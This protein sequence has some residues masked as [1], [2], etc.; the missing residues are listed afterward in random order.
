M[1]AIFGICSGDDPEVRR[2]EID[3]LRSYLAYRGPDVSG[4]WAE[5]GIAIGNCLLQTTPESLY[6]AMPAGEAVGALRITAD[7]RL[8]NR[9]EL[10]GTLGL[11]DL[12]AA[13]TPDSRLILEA[14]LKWGEDCP[15]HLLGD[16]AFAIWDR[17][18]RT[19]FCARDQF[20][21]KPF[22]YCE[23]K[24][25]FAFCSC[26]DGLLQF[27]WVPRRLN[28][29]RLASHLTLFYG[30][31]AT[32]FYADILRLP[33]A[34]SLRVNQYGV[35]LARYWKLDPEIET[36]RDSDGQ[37]IEEFKSIFQEAVKA[38]LRTNG[39]PGSMLSGGLDS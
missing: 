25:C 14:F 19:L 7:A 30:D 34:H 24:G 39:K 18:T 36:L 5:A 3:R 10:I 22:Y 26:V 1:S 2:T 9:E 20:G 11:K 31:T 27:E 6:E 35:R 4:I 29:Q 32:T 28:E 16:F 23:P 15:A 8:D 37:Y 33:P 38:R 17:R 13:S 12:P 21:V